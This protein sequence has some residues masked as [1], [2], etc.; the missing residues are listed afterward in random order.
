ML[1]YEIKILNDE[2]ISGTTPIDARN[3]W[4]E[5]STTVADAIVMEHPNRLARSLLVQE[6]ALAVLK[7]AMSGIP[8]IACN[9]PNRFLDQSPTGSFLRQYGH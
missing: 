4:A 5:L 8:I 6:Q 3:S 1:I 2:G 9:D 7:M